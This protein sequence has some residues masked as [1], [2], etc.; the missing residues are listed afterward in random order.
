MGSIETADL[1]FGDNKYKQSKSNK[2]IIED[3]VIE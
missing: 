3:M 1:L 2:E